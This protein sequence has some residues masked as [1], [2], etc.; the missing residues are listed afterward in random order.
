MPVSSEP[1]VLPITGYGVTLREFTSAD[2][3]PLARIISDPGFGKYY[4]FFLPPGFAESGCS[5]AAQE[6]VLLATSLIAPRPETG[7]RENYKVAIEIDGQLAGGIELD[8]ISQAGKDKRDIGYFVA[9]AYRGQGVSSKAS[10]LILD[11]FF[12]NSSYDFIYATVHPTGNPASYRV[13]KQKL[14]FEETGDTSTMV[15][16]GVV[17]PRIVLK[18]TREEFYSV[19]AAFDSEGRKRNP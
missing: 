6:F 11:A 12:K 14:G 1:I 19:K 8:E 15:V 16:N 5:K 13:L 7:I 3:I 17:E 2:A 10:M 4:A 9:P 18:L